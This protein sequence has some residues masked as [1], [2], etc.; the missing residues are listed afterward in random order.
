MA[1]GG[2]DA[3]DAG[4]GPG[5]GRVALLRLRSP[6][7]ASVVGRRG[8]QVQ[9]LQRGE[10]LIDLPELDFDGSKA[11]VQT[12]DIGAELGVVAAQAGHLDAQRDGR[13]EDGP[14][15]PLGV[16]AQHG[17]RIAPTMLRDN[18]AVR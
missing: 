9:P 17:V 14:D 16:S 8:G 6:R 5:R 3:L 2:A 15:D 11:V 1:V 12:A 4:G 10:P 18:G 7:C 13:G